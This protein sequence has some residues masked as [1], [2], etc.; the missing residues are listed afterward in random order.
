MVFPVVL[1]AK[2]N[3]PSR[4]TEKISQ[5]KM[6]TCTQKATPMDN[7][8]KHMVSFFFKKNQRDL[9]TYIN[10]KSQINKLKAGNTLYRSWPC[11]TKAAH[12]GYPK[13]EPPEQSLPQL[14]CLP[15][16][17]LSGPQFASLKLETD[18]LQ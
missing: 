13:A 1:S 7:P 10:C 2:L 5:K 18:P 14:C 11:I 15:S 3:S 16:S 12:Q 8:G 17:A 9:E 6:I 4:K